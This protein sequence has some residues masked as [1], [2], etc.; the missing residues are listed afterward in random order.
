MSARGGHGERGEVDLAQLYRAEIRPH[1][2]VEI[3]YGDKPK[4]RGRERRM[5]CPLH[6]NARGANFVINVQTLE[7][8]CHSA[9]QD[10]GDAIK[11]VQKTEGL[12][13]R[14]A[15]LELGRRVGVFLNKEAPPRPRPAKP[16]P[17]VVERQEREEPPRYPPLEL[18]EGLWEA[19]QRVDVDA[20]TSAYLRG[21]DLDP[22]AVAD[23]DLARAL[24]TSGA[25]PRE[26]TYQRT[27]WRE[28]GH[29]LLVPLY[30]AAGRRR[31][32]LAR[33]L[34][35]GEPKTLPFAGYERKRLV[36]ADGLAR[37]ML[38]R[39]ARPD[40][41]EDTAFRV[42]IAEGETD[43][44]AGVLSFSEADEYAPAVLGIGSGAW[45]QA[46][47]DRIPDGSVVIIASDIDKAGDAYEAQIRKTLLARIMAGTIEV[48]K[49]RAAET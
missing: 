32:L 26:C 34:R 38:A 23:L 17:R 47:A 2:S 33:R 13:Y 48:M 36:M 4:G 44:L 29:R 30:D 24:P 37:Q 3:V 28:T 45:S 22:I 15:V 16:A 46:T 5:P 19:A 20:E 49:W 6:G 12:G 18:V 1:L 11:F 7:Y 39:G 31:S 21:R 43:Y 14:D 27:S 25:L 9:C 8:Y 42:Y 40:W 35:V 41:W 10:G